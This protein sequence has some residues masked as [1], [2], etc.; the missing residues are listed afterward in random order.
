VPLIR[1]IARPGAFGLVL[2]AYDL[3]NRLPASQRRKLL[4]GARKHGPTVARAAASQ[5]KARRAANA[6]KKK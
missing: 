5:V 4:Q 6:A 3:W 2:T 1:H